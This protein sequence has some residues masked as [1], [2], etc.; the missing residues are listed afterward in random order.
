MAKLY[1]RYFIPLTI[2]VLTLN[3]CNMPGKTEPTQEISGAIHTIAAKTVSVQLTLDAERQDQIIDTPNG[4]GDNVEQPSITPSPSGEAPPTATS[5]PTITDTPQPTP[6]NTPIPCDHI[7]FVKDISVPD[8]T[9]MVPGQ[10]F[11]KTWRLKNSGSCTWTSGYSVVFDSG[12]AMGAP[13]SKQLTVGTIAPGEVIDVSLDLKA[14]ADPGSYRGNFKLRNSDG[15][16]F[17]LGNKSSPFFV[18]ILIPESSG[19]MFDFISMAEEAIWGS[20]T[21]TISYTLPGDVSLAYGGPVAGTDAYVTT[22][23]NVKLED[24]RN[25]GSILETHPQNNGYIIGRF[26]VYLIGAGDKITAKIGFLAEE[27]GGCGLGDVQFQ[28]NY[29]FGDDLGSMTSLGSW[30]KFC[31]GSFRK[32][33]IDLDGLVGKSVR[34]YLIVSANGDSTDDKAIWDSLGVMR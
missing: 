8:G 23:K 9:E 20:G 26:P 30:N 2:L 5:E 13:A 6:T 31:N 29:T 27:G 14:P 25:S 16:V 4:N 34:F 17:G 33:T 22:H 1:F 10:Q 28:V 15:K 24:G 12:E 19:V 32:I 7:T 3:A 11:T 18:E 21:G